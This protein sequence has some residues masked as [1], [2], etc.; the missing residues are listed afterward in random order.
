MSLHCT[1]TP[2]VCDLLAD[3]RRDTARQTDS[4]TG[5]SGWVVLYVVEIR[6]W[7]R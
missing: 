2:A 5:W 4:Q 7:S 6:Q 1:E 3:R